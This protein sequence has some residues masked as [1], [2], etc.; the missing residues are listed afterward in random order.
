VRFIARLATKPKRILKRRSLALLISFFGSSTIYVDVK[1]K[2][3]GADIASIPDGYVVDMTE[4]AMP[5]LYVLEN[6]IVSHDPFKHIGIQMLKFVT[7]FDEAKLTPP[8][9]T[10]ATV[11][12]MPSKNPSKPAG[13]QRNPLIPKRSHPRSDLRKSILP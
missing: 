3:K 2:I 10:R 13:Q 11:L 7:G 12:R 9:S 1:K 5:R 4:P 8:A 6:E